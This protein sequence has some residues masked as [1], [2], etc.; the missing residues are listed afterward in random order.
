[1][2]TTLTTS[3]K[4]I[5]SFKAST[6]AT[7]KVFAKATQNTSAN[8]STISMYATL[9]GTGNS[10]SFSGGTLKY[11]L[12][13]QTQSYSLGSTSY[14]G[15]TITYNTFTKTRSHAS[16]GTYTNKTISVSISTNGS[17]N[18]SGSGKINCATI[19]R[20][21][22]ITSVSEAD[23]GSNINIVIGNN[24]SSFKNTVTWSCN[25]LSGTVVA[26]NGTTLDKVASGTYTWQIPTSILAT[27]PNSS[28]AT[29][30]LTNTTYSGTTQIGTTT[31]ATTKA[32]VPNSSRPTLSLVSKVETDESVISALPSSA[33]DFT[34]PIINLSKPSFTFTAKALDGATLNWLYLT[35]GSNT[36]AIQLSG[37][38]QTI[39]YTFE[40]PMTSPIVTFVLYDSR[41]LTTSTPYT[42]DGTSLARTYNKP[43]FKTVEIKRPSIIYSTVEGKI[44]GTYTTENIDGVTG[45]AI[46]LGY[47][48]KEVN[49]ENYGS[50]VWLE[51]DITYDTTNGTWAYEGTM[52][53]FAEYNKS[54]YVKLIL[55]DH[56]VD[57]TIEYIF[58]LRKSI[59]TFSAGETDL[60]INGELNLADENNENNVE[61]FG[62]TG[63]PRYD[64]TQTYEEGAYVIYGNSLQK[65]LGTTTGAFDST[66]W[67]ET[68]IMN[69]I[70]NGSG[71]K[72]TTLWE[73]TFAATSTGSISWSQSKYD[74]DTLRIAYR[75]DNWGASNVQFKDVPNIKSGMNATCLDIIYGYS[76][77]R[78]NIR[79]AVLNIYEKSASWD[80]ARIQ[81]RELSTSAVTS[82]GNATTGSTISV[83]GIYGIGGSGA[84]AKTE[85]NNYIVMHLPS[86]QS[87]SNSYTKLNLTTYISSGTRLAESSGQVVIG[88]GVRRIKVSGT[89]AFSKGAAGDKYMRITKNY[90]ASN[91]DGTTITMQLRREPNTGVSQ[92]VASEIIC[93]VTEGDLIGMYVYGGSGDTARQTLSNDMLQTYMKVEVID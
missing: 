40:N 33:T 26:T 78:Q 45:N 5:F 22:S 55:G 54:Y 67:E 42:F 79:S 93:N 18:G 59:P 21:N 77:S 41:G 39:T 7:V 65:C 28:S 81:Y 23:I 62:L 91:I 66:K 13:G 58:M 70:K 12:D 49:E 52:G 27:I 50:I 80:S 11:T 74:F 8:T 73:G 61:I 4:Q 72:V 71:A 56:V 84:V 90:N 25:G 48:Y 38:T 83:I 32:N 68:D 24:S 9:T 31:K 37:T 76:S 63:T 43:V 51:N 16:D 46:A 92:L 20:Q 82:G 44:T 75:L 15:K 85:E 69:E 60:Q 53:S 6:Y 17:P 36:K 89:F 19:P 1:M 86:S 64:S 30:T 87:F 29:I 88:S 2:A 14:G 3:Y 57:G 47:Q 34:E 35:T 10:G